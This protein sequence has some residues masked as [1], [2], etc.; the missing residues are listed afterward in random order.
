MDTILKNNL[1]KYIINKKTNVS[2]ISKISGIS[3]STLSRI[4]SGE[5]KNPTSST[6]EQLSKAFQIP[7]SVLLNED[8]SVKDDNINHKNIKDRL[9]YLMNKNQIN[10]D[11]LSEITGI[12][13]TGIKSILSG[14]TKKPNFDTCSKL[15]D[16]CGISV[17][18]LKCED[19]LLFDNEEMYKE[20]AFIDFKNVSEWLITRDKFLVNEYKKMLVDK[21]NG[22]FCIKVNENI[23]NNEFEIGDTFV[24]IE[25]NSLDKGKFIAEI[26]EKIVFCHISEIEDIF[27]KYR[28]IGFAN[29]MIIESNKIKILAKLY[30]VKV[31]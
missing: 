9:L 31:N 29:K 16:F 24:F 26:N 17:K 7:V 6:I 1:E 18:Q 8:V 30:E 14:E 19:D 22:V 27:V 11:T 12:S 3:I 21:K 23:Y 28:I 10:I 15:S 13:Y 20:I 2:K 5:I 25:C 4:L